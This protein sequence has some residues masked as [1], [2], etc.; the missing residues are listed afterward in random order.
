MDNTYFWTSQRVLPPPPL[1]DTPVYIN[2]C[3]RVL[4][5]TADYI[6]DYIA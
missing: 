1:P 5:D 3:N 6:A 4:G 2:P